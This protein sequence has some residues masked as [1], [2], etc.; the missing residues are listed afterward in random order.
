MAVAYAPLAALPY[1]IS[2]L[3]HSLLMLAAL[4]TAVWLLRPLVPAVDRYPWIATAIALTFYPMLRAVTGGQNTA[5][6][7]MLI[8]LALRLD[9]DG[10]PVLAG[11]AVA[12]LLYKPQFGIPLGAL[13]FVRPRWPIINGWLA[14]AAVFVAG[15]MVAAGTGWIATWWR[16]ATAFAEINEGINGFLFVSVPGMIANWLGSQSGVGRVLWVTALVVTALLAL[17]VW[18]QFDDAPRRWALTA[19]AVVLVL[20]Q[21]LYYEAGVAL[22][23]LATLGVTGSVLAAIWLLSW[24][25]IAADA[26]SWSPLGIITPVALGW[27]LRRA[28]TERAIT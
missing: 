25:Q 4:G 22:L 18:L 7:V 19:L 9:H 10:R 17:R 24:T 11:V 20:P 13:L 3:V 28:R 26:L 21:A 27:M 12:L 23:G 15:G 14:G 16:E 2:Y 5:L 1:R 8:A 6:T